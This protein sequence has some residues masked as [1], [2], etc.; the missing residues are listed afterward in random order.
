M[1][2]SP[3]CSGGPSGSDWQMAVV[4]IALVLPC[5]RRGGDGE[6]GKGA[7]V[8]GGGG[9]GDSIKVLSLQILSKDIISCYL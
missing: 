2:P 6:V 8:V 7:H 3:W 1:H 5:K 9:G 4:I